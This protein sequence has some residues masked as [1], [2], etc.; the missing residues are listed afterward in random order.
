TD[1]RVSL[2]VQLVTNLTLAPANGQ[3][4]PVSGAVSPRR[5]P[6]KQPAADKLFRA[7]EVRL[8]ILDD[9]PTIGR[10]I[11][12]AFAD[13]DFTI[14]II[15][16]PTQIE[17]RLQDHEYHVVVLDYVI[18]GIDSEKLLGWVRAY[19]PDAAIIVVT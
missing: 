11:G 1:L 17:A 6:D 10:L 15:S 14:H 7:G 12:S 18:P 8:L 9:D 2:E 13:K 3:G 19:Q 5:A 4:T 16:D